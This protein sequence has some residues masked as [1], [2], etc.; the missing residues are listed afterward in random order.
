MSLPRTW[1][2]RRPGY[3]LFI[4]REMTSVAVA[5]YAVILLVGLAA[6]GDTASFRAWA[7]WLGSPWGVGAQMLIL[8]MALLHTVTWIRLTPKV[9][10]FWQGEEQVD[11]EWI[12]GLNTIAWLGVSG[13]IA[14]VVFW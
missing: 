4:A 1:W 14:W 11:P 2:L 9:L 3:R 8:A 7:H 5:A 12:V 6:A 10:V 13:L